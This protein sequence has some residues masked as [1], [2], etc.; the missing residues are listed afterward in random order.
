[1]PRVQSGPWQACS[2]S[3]G[4]GWQERS[5]LC[6][7]FPGYLTEAWHCAGVGMQSALTSS[8]CRL[9][10]LLSCQ[11]SLCYVDW[12]PLKPCILRLEITMISCTRENDVEAHKR[13]CPPQTLSLKDVMQGH[14]TS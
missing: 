7:A 13:A 5:L 8:P 1:M 10:H 14:N 6:S 9:V 4:S 2:A 12:F 3:C 11:F